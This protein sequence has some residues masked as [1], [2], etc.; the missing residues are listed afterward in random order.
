MNF[1]TEKMHPPEDWPTV[2][3]IYR[4]GLDTGQATFETKVPDWA[5]WDKNHLPD[6]RLVAKS[7][8]LVVGWA[9]LSPVSRRFVYRGVAEV[10]IYLAAAARGQGIGKALLQALI[11]ES[12]RAGIWTL[13][14]GIFPENIASLT[15]HQACGFREVGVRE[16]IGQ[17]N[18]VWRDVV[19]LER[20]SKVAGI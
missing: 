4:E 9:A 13:Q 5:A 6:C 11:A 15:L 10:S 19:L 1:T 2:Q 18:G 14:A 3:A 7:N 20:R 17:M 12:E 16:R 8:G